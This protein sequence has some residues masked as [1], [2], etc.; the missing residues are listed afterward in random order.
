MNKIFFILLT[1]SSCSAA[2]N[3]DEDY[4]D[5]DYL[6]QE[7][8]SPPPS[9]IEGN[10]GDGDWKKHLDFKRPY[11]VMIGNESGIFVKRCFCGSPVD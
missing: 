2:G 8:Y 7:Q 5:K 11:C 3:D 6:E 4:Q 1:L 10:F 9:K